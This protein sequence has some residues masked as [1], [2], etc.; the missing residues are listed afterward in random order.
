MIDA[1]A[2]VKVQVLGLCVLFSPDLG[3]GMWSSAWLQTHGL[4][5]AWLQLVGLVWA[6]SETSENRSWLEEEKNLYRLER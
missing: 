2:T 3:S 4:L 1:S 6:G 5:E